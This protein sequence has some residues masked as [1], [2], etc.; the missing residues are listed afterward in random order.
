MHNIDLLSLSGGDTISSGSQAHIQAYICLR[1][2]VQQ[3]IVSRNLLILL[4]LP[5]PVGGYQFV[6]EQGGVLSILIQDNAEFVRRQ[7]NRDFIGYIE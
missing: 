1:D 3:H 5:K 4:E 7:E 2:I 6:E